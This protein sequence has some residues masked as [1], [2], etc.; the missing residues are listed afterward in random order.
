[1]TYTRYLLCSTINLLLRCEEIFRYLLKYSHFPSFFLLK[2]I[3]EFESKENNRAKA[4]KLLWVLWTFRDFHAL[5]LVLHWQ[6]PFRPVHIPSAPSV[7][8]GYSHWRTTETIFINFVMRAT[9][10][11]PTITIKDRIEQ[12]WRLFTWTPIYIS[13][14]PH[15]M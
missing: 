9:E 15:P 12:N 14:V 3:R 2:I 5:A 10:K 13:S 4:P 1:L 7:R 11:C 8:V 6:A